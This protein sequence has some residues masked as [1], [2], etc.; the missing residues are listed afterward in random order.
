MINP[1]MAA[2][3]SRSAG[4]PPKQRQPEHRPVRERI[5]DPGRPQQQH[6]CA[7]RG[8]VEAAS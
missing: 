7:L 2:A 4:L 6:S 3:C 1:E 5:K 8:E